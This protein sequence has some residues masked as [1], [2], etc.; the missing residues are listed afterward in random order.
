MGS[1][2]VA[3]GVFG[4]RWSILIC[5]NYVYFR[6]VSGLSGCIIQDAG[7]AVVRQIRACC[8]AFDGYGSRVRKHERVFYRCKGF[9]RS[10]E[11]GC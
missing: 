1:G 9:I 7:G 5:P 11:L 8:S 6:L 4:A 10:V 2:L 3:R